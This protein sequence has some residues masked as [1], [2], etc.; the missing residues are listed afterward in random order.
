MPQIERFREFLRSPVRLEYFAEKEKQGWR[1][2][3]A[4]WEREGEGLKTR[5][6]NYGRLEAEIPYGLRVAPDCRTL[7]EDPFEK[8]ALLL[9]MDCIVRDVGI[10][11]M[12]AELNRKG[13]RTRQGANWSTIAVF[14][15]LP[16]L[17]EVGPSIFPTHDW[18]ERRRHLVRLVSGP[19]QA[20]SV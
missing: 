15:M 13:F 1:L 20:A 7:E 8:E 10:A 12:A 14:E 9:M 16:R 19:G 5:E 17:I 11:T 6:T 4:E 3:A 18:A 2:V